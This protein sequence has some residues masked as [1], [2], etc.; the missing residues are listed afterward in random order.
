MLE[1]KVYAMSDSVFTP[2][3]A[4][5][6]VGEGDLDLQIAQGLGKNFLK[7]CFTIDLIY[8]FSISTR[9]LVVSSQQLRYLLRCRRCS[10]LQHIGRWTLWYN[11]PCLG[12]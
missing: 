6:P 9:N 4:D 5:G 10:L 12:N 8:W 1:P 7:A 2:G 3:S 11:P